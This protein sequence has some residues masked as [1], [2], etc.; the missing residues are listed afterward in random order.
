MRPPDAW[1]SRPGSGPPD[2]GSDGDRG[3]ARGGRRRARRAGVV[4][5]RRGAQRDRRP[6]RPGRPRRAV[7]AASAAAGAPR[8]AGPRRLD[9]PGR[10][11]LRLP[12][13]D[14][15][16]G[17]G[18]RR[19]DAS[20]P[21]SRWSRG[22]R[23]SPT[24]ATTSPAGAAGRT[25]SSPSSSAPSGRPARRPRTAGRCGSQPLPRPLRAGAGRARDRRPARPRP[26]ARSRRRARPTWRARWPARCPSR[27]CPTPCSSGDPAICGCCAASAIVDPASLDDYRA[28]GGYDAAAARVRARPGGRDPRGD[29][30]ASCS[31]AA[32]PRSRPAASGTPSPRQPVRPHYLVC[33]ADE[34]EPGTFKDRV[35]MEQRSL[36][37]RRGDDDRR[38][39]HRLPST[40]TSTCA[41]SIRW[42]WERLAGAITQARA[43]RLPRRRH[44]GPGAALRHRDARG[45]GAY[46][47]G[48]ETALFNSIEGFRGEPRNKPPFPVEAGLFGKPTVVNNVETLV[49]V[50][51]I[52]LEGGGRVRRRSAPRARRAR[53]SSACPAASQRPGLY[54][55]P[56]GATLRE[57]I[58]LAGGVEP[59]RRLQAVLLGGA[60]GAF[61]GPESSTCRSRSRTRARPAR[62]S[63]PASSWSSTIRSDSCRSCCASPRSSATSRAASACRAG[64]APCARRR[65]SLRLANGRPRGSVDDEIAL[66]DEIGAA[67]R[68]ASICGLGQTAASAIESAHPHAAPVRRGGNGMSAVPVDAAAHRRARRS[69]ARRCSV[70][71]G[72]RRSCRPAAARVRT[73]R[74]SATARRSRR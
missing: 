50:L 36:R 67:M 12:P 1:R 2:P 29:R 47:C 23:W 17:R 73:R 31:A 25:S 65:R 71:R 66:L 20:T 4:L 9:Q 26:S 27:W 22:R 72:R 60:A 64:S 54:E 70:P 38:L 6:L 10:A 63:A 18:L 53:G 41:A 32:A 3:R 46:I 48:E 68:D 45:A 15:P 8:G 49:N 56:F 42:R 43:A 69:T 19:R 61:V 21:S 55:V 37:R 51:D 14:D 33:N 24:S 58:E 40:A 62:R 39:R 30:V 16:A 34:S 74:R 11:R 7:A 44:H 5:G 59:G 28:H 52:V 13:A 35:L 57:L